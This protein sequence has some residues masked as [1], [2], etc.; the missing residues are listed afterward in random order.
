MKEN[1]DKHIEA[2]VDKAM[3]SLPLETPSVEFTQ[4]VMAQIKGS[5]VT[6]TTVYK[7]LISKQV[8]TLIFIGIVAVFIWTLFGTPVEGESWFDTIDYGFIT[9]NKVSNVISNFKISQTTGYAIIMLSIMV[10][11]QIPLLKHYF[12]KRLMY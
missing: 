8:W 4:H 1:V 9:N 11:I 5:S 2:L 7:P 6:I 12:N 3:Q 10:G